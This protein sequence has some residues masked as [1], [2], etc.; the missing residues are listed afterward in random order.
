M[1]T[2]RQRIDPTIRTLFIPQELDDSHIVELIRRMHSLSA[3]RLG[4]VMS[5]IAQMG[6]HPDRLLEGVFGETKLVVS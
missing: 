6:S 2:M 5:I 4:R 3:E 1:E